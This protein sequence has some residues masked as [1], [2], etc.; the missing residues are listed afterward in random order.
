MLLNNQEVVEEVNEKINYLKTNDNENK[1]TH[2]LWD[3]VKAALREVYVNTS[4]PQ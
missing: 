2:N 4:L 1:P 3:A